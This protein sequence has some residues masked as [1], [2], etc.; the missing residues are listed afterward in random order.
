V[1]A[2]ELKLP[3]LGESVTEGTLGKWLK[4]PGD[5]VEKYELLVEVQTDKVSTEIPSPVSGTLKDIKVQEGETVPNGTVLAILDVAGVEAGAPQ[6]G[7]RDERQTAAAAP[8]AAAPA[9]PA[10]PTTAGAPRAAAAPPRTSAPTPA[11]GLSPAAAE[12]PGPRPS[13]PPSTPPRITRE[14]PAEERPAAQAAPSRPFGGAP[15]VEEQL[16]ERGPGRATPV[17]RRLA[18]EHGIDLQT[19]RGTGLNGRITR[20]DVEQ[21]IAAARAGAA[22]PSAPS[23]APAAPAAP[24][25][26]AAEAPPR[27]A[28][29][30]G[31]RV[32]PFTQMR[33]AIA[34]NLV[35]SKFTAPHAHAV[36]EVDMTNLMRYRDTVRAEFAQ[37]EGFDLSPAAFIVKA[38]CEA[39]RAVPLVN[40]TWTD[41]GIV[42]KK[43]VNVGYA[44][45]LGDEGLVVP[46]IKKADEKSLAG[47][48]RSI[49]DIVDRAKARKLN[50]QDFEGGTFTVNNTGPLG[51]FVSSPIIVPGQAAIASSES[52]R[53]RLVVLDDDQIAI[54]SMMNLV[55][56]FDHRIIDGATAARFLAA[57]RD[58]LQSVNQAVPI[59]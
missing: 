52:I 8:A 10:A 15:A 58:W 56:G 21:A 19:L 1:A 27:A 16:E 17:V 31:D 24:R 32:I 33:R 38:A 18:A 6:D 30:P 54:R 3:K 11:A 23:A 47:L 14:A 25:P 43:D 5:K 37:R 55:I 4:Q 34:E 53:K 20:Q 9:A 22:V 39:L 36:M 59:Y 41:G 13:A 49:R 7:H 45:A 12:A 28:P 29:M 57:M 50:V 48:M 46:V 35:R 51:T 44:V 26:A 42:V 40:S 2:F